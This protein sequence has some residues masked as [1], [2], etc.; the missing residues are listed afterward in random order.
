MTD[1]RLIDDKE[2]EAAKC[3]SKLINDSDYMTGLFVLEK[4]GPD[5]NKDPFY[6]G[7]AITLGSSLESSRDDNKK[8]H[9]LMKKLLNYCIDN[10]KYLKKE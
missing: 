10:C 4:M 1:E 8:S 3:I 9:E 2:L 5:F 6:A 7:L